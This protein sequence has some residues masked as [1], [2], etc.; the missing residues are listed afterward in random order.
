MTYKYL[1]NEIIIWGRNKG[2][3]G[4]STQAAQ[5]EKT[6]EEVAELFKAIRTGDIAEQKDAYGDIVVTLLMGC[7]IAGFDLVE[8]LEGAYNVI[9]KRKGQMVDGLF[10]KDA[11][12]E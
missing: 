10:V 11:T 12:C 3:I 1:E 7:E 2:I 4:N 6:L 8:C 9:S 5:A